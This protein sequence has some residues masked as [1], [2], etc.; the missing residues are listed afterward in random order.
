MRLR[1]RENEEKRRRAI[2]RDAEKEKIRDREIEGLRQL[3]RGRLR[4][5]QERERWT[6]S[7]RKE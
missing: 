6:Q 4:E 3:W 1:F 7:T 5:R 2:D